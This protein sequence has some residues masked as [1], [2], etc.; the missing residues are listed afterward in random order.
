MQQTLTKLFQQY[1]IIFWYGKEEMLEEFNE[2]NLDDVHKITVDNNEF[3][4]KYR[5]MRQEPAHKFLLYFMHDVPPHAENWLLDLQLANYE[6]HTDRAAIIIQDLGIDFDYKP[7]I[8]EYMGFFQNKKRQEKLKQILVNEPLSP[9]QLKYKLLAITLKGNDISLEQLLLNLIEEHALGKEDKIA[10]LEKFKLATFFWEEIRNKY[11][12]KTESASVYDFLL[13]LFKTDLQNILKSASFLNREAL[14]LL[15]KWKDSSRFNACLE[16]LSEKV[17]KDLNLETA[18]IS[19]DYKDL[20]TNDSFQLIDQK[21]ISG[22]VKDV[23]NKT[24]STS[25]LEQIIKRRENTW[26]FPKYKDHY[27]AVNY[28]SKLITQVESALFDFKS[29]KEGIDLYVSQ[30]YKIDYN[31]RKFLLHYSETNQSNSLALIADNIEKI[32]SNSYLLKLNDYWQKYVDQGNFLHE[33]DLVQQR[34]FFKRYIAPY[35]DKGNRI[36]VIISDALRYESGVE[37]LERL[38]KENRFTSSLDA[39]VSSVPTYTQLGMAALLPN[40]T[41]TYNEAI[42]HVFV[43]GQISN[44]TANRD[45]LLKQA[46][47]GR[48]VAIKAADFIEIGKKRDEGRDFVKQ[49]DVLYIYHNGIDKTGDDKMTEEKVFKATEAEFDH[50]IKLLKTIS[51]LN[52]TNAIITADHGYIYQNLKLEESDFSEVDKAGQVFKDNRRFIIGKNLKE[53]SSARKFTAKELYLDDDT[54]FLIPKSINRF[55]IQG[56]GS[57]FVHGGASLQELII[58]V[59][60]FTMKKE[61]TVKKV[62][63]DII[64]SVSKITSNNVIITFYQEEPVEEQVLARELRVAFY[65]KDGTLLSDIAY[66]NFDSPDSYAQSREQRYKFL[67]TKEL[68]QYNNQDIVLRLEEPIP[69]A[70]SYK[71]YKEKSYPVMIS[72]TSDF[73][74]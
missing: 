6:F 69:K 74:F 72:F 63:I 71:I 64:R 42:D 59:I 35:A 47:K 30:Y 61:K 54:E 13:E 15:N 73:D 32:Y 5:V 40:N 55:R 67:L 60:E 49:F 16:V 2:I 57:R 4:I 14:L 45:K 41:L 10:D 20:M 1:R 22:L 27:Y 51:N 65:A 9:A 58:P 17:A 12:Y 25:D 37:L 33:H 19:C 43:D 28:A 8:N 39:M 7:I 21:I 29:V 11:A 26:W 46:L 50:I 70:A 3:S 62:E 56:A 24:I 23:L 38:S 52:G 44:G 66:L 48:A 36:F 31:Y 18:L 68:G 53:Q 34:N